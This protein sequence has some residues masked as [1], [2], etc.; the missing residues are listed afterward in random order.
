MRPTKRAYIAILIA[1]IGTAVSAHAHADDDDGDRIAGFTH[2]FEYTGEVFADAHGGMRRGGV[3]TGL[4]H[5][6]FEHTW[7]KWSL[8]GDVYAPHGK[9]FNGRY[10]GGFTDVSNI[11]AVH[12]VRVHELW[13]ERSLGRASL[14][15]GL[16]A[17]DTEFWGPDTANL[18]ISSAFGA[19]SVVSGNLPNSPI[20]PQGV[21]GARL[22][23]DLGHAGILR[24]AVLDGDGGDPASENR[25]GLHISLNQGALLLAE[26]QPVFGSGGKQKTSV[27]LGTYYHTGDFLNVHGDSVRSDFG[28]IGSVDRAIDARLSVFARVGVALSDRSTVPWEIETGFNLSPVFGASDKL[29]VALAYVD[30]N[31]SPAVTRTATPLRHEIILE[32]TLDLPLTKWLDL[33]PDVQYIIDPGGTATARNAW[34]VGIRVSLHNLARIGIL[35]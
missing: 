33:Q 21:L 24:M 5:V 16:L 18:F 7:S 34:V 11:D 27:R 22:A 26:Y 23:F 4:A 19:P 20:Y 17:A 12:Q 14:R 1:A 8:H 28:F 2:R 29:G 10:V 15:V 9:S 31:R 25:H 32:S 30:L 35:R 13:S 6:S 3:Y